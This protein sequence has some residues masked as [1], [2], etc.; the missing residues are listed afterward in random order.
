MAGRWEDF[1]KDGDR[2]WL[3]YRTQGDDKVRP[4]HAEL[5]G[6]TLPASDKFWDTYYPPNGWNCRCTVVQVRKKGDPT[7]HEDAMRRAAV[8]VGPKDRMFRFNP[9]KEE[10]VF[11]AY[12]PYTISKCITCPKAL[13]LA[14]N[15]SAKDMCVVC[16]GPIKE[17]AD[18]RAALSSL[19]DLKG[20]A[21]IDKLNE[22]TQLRV[23]KELI[24]APGVFSAISEA[25]LDFQNL[26]DGAKK[27]VRH[28]YRV[29]ILPNPKG[30]RTADYIFIKKKFIG[31]Y[32]LKTI[33]GHNSI[34]NRFMDSIGQANRVVLNMNTTYN[35]KS[36]AKEIRHYFEENIE[37]IEV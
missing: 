13:N 7:T 25:D 6:I 12:N 11:P 30:I 36:L 26:K 28:G 22:I 14:A 24:D 19:S 37:A 1:K 31:L 17:S 16:Q 9:G 29:F 10:R 34:G 8:A 5:N 21:F 18:V 15:I 27:A 3:Q 33:S 23:F 2:Y 4:E 35:A 20:K 32:D